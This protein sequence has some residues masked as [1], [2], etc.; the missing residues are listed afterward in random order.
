MPFGKKIFLL[1]CL[2]VFAIAFVLTKKSGHYMFTKSNSQIL[3]QD[4]P[5]EDIQSPSIS[6]KGSFYDERTFFSSIAKAKETEKRSDISALVV[7]H[8][9]LAAELIAGPF[10]HVSGRKI[11]TVVVIGP[12]HEN[13][14]RD[15]ISSALASWQTPYGSL[16]ENKGLVK[17]LIN[18][19]LMN[20]DEKIFENEHSIGA[21][22]P[23]IKYYFPEAKLVPI[24]LTSNSNISDA[25]KISRWLTENLNND[26]LVVLSSDF[27]HYLEKSDAEKKD[28]LTK[29][30][31]EKRSIS[32]I[33]Q[34]GNDNV[35]CPIGLAMILMYAEKKN[36]KTEITGHLNSYDLTPEKPAE[37]TSYYAISFIGK[38]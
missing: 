16:E 26:A 38:Q 23:Y 11:S 22:A 7:P 8:H 13:K 35:D 6:L 36:L 28:L 14:G 20:A 15:H 34:L 33:A 25:E 21:M 3:E 1:S 19:F 12:N 9:L 32:K 31:I 24:I 10:M 4:Q 29:E 17:K 5:N 27:S 30:L 2:A 18:D 37:T